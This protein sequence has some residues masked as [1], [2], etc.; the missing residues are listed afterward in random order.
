MPLPLPQHR[1]SK[2]G[3]VAR[4]FQEHERRA[5][6]ASAGTLAEIASAMTAHARAREIAQAVTEAHA[7]G[8]VRVSPLAPPPSF[9]TFPP[10]R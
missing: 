2:P 4:I 10:P 3:D 9:S 6:A 8:G 7:R 5:V 1:I